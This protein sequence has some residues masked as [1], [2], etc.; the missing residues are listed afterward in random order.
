TLEYVEGGTLGQRAGGRPQPPRQAAACLEVLARA[1]HYAHQRGIVHRDLK[2]ANVLLCAP[3]KPQA[4]ACG[5]AGAQPKIA[6]FGLAQLLE[7]PP[8]HPA[9]DV[10]MGTPEYMA[11][12]QAGQ[13]RAAGRAADVYALGAI[14]Y[15]LLTGRPPLQAASPLETL[16]LVRFEEPVPARQLN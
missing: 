5:L 12:E 10:V 14:L 9:T 15:T 7:G 2:P 3:A 1:A 8:T 13:S 11:P 6:D 4:V 16:W